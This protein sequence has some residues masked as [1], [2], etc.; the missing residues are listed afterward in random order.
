[1]PSWRTCRGSTPTNCDLA[2]EEIARLATAVDGA[3]ISEFLENLPRSRA[4]HGNGEQLRLLATD[5]PDHWTIVRQPTTF[6]WVHNGS[7]DQGDAPAAPTVTVR[8]PTADL[9]LLLWGRRRPTH[10]SLTVTGDA[11][12]LTHRQQHAVI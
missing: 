4:L 1:V 11:A 6:T 7:D 9:Y 12:L 5:H 3:G 2:S 10:H 8:A